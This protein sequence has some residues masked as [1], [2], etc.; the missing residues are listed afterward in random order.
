MFTFFFVWPRKSAAIA[1]RNFSSYHQRDS[2]IL[3]LIRSRLLDAVRS[4]S[5]RKFPPRK[6]SQ[7]ERKFYRVQG[8]EEMSPEEKSSSLHK[9][10]SESNRIGRR[11]KLSA[12]C[13]I[14]LNCPFD[15]FAIPELIQLRIVQRTGLLHNRSRLTWLINEKFPP[16]H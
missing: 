5:R 1:I 16:A 12:L 2:E 10:H 13:R 11:K 3:R 14:T 7:A 4:S 8:L 15:V 6:A 9:L